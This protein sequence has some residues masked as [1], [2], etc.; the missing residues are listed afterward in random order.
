MTTMAPLD[1]AV[2]GLGVGEQ[3]ARA[4]ARHPACRLRWLYDLDAAR[5]R[6]VAARV[7]AGHAA[8]ADSYSVVTSDPSVR[9]VSIASYDDAHY[10]QTVEALAARKHVFIEK[11]LCR[12][13]DELRALK[14][15]WQVS[16]QPQLQ[17][18]LVLRAAPLYRWL[19]AA[20]AAG[21]LGE[22]YAF[23]GEYLYGRLEKITN[24]WRGTVEDYSVVQGGAIHLIDLMLWLLNERPTAAAATGNRIAT[25]GSPF[26]Y[27]DFVTAMLRFGDGHGPVARITAN[28]GCVHRHHHVVRVFGTKATFIYDDA[29]ARLHRSRD[30]EERAEPLPHAPLPTSKGDLIPEFVNAVRDGADSTGAAQREFDVVSCCLAIDEAARTG[31]WRPIDYV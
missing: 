20:I 17:S 1:V 24:G 14:D 27:D 30:P 5:A 29:G 22:V 13:L 3:H 25:E 10:S 4:Y 7:G 21:E 12:S 28:F 18:N 26:R 8:T 15:C 2:V 11:P 19:R 23:D 16:G 6:D 31:S 9:I